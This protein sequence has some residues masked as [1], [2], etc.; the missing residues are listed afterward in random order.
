LIEVDAPPRTISA[1]ARHPVST[2]LA[3]IAPL[4]LLDGFLPWE[5]WCGAGSGGSS[6][7]C[8]SASA[9]SGSASLLGVLA[10]ALCLTFLVATLKAGPRST[11]GAV[12]L[13]VFAGALTALVAKSAIV[14]H[15][16]T[17]AGSANPGEDTVR[18][19]A[20]IAIALLLVGGILLMVEV[21]RRPWLLKMASILSVI[22]VV[23]GVGVIYARTGLAWWGGP[24]AAPQNLGGGNAEKVTV[25]PG[26]PYLFQSLLYLDN[27]G[28]V[29]ATL[30]GVDLVDGTGRIDVLGTYVVEGAAPCGA[31]A[32]SVPGLDPHRCAYPLEGAGI[33]PGARSVLLAIA[34]REDSPGVYRS[35]WFRIRYHV[36]P[37]PF[38]VFRT[39]QLVV[40]AP[41]P[42][43]QGCPG[44][45]I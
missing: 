35:G 8:F 23:S 7:R 29:S 1:A 45:G 12:R 18:I 13:S 30:D 20:F 34:F 21:A 17:L 37:L 27:P 31:G 33:G 15:N 19:G 40:C 41:S 39:D 4:L 26:R 44:S 16:T 6:Y 22:L 28:H 42:G 32:V 36:G 2:W 14:D 11:P 38:Q 25:R 9:W 43:K 3:A 10:I 5:R 24:L